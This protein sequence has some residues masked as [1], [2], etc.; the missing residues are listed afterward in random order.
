MH[1]WEARMT[2]RDNN[3]VVRPFEWGPEWAGRWPTLE[4]FPPPQEQ[5]DKAAMLDRKSIV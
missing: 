2:A 5:S 3:R 1:D 4:N